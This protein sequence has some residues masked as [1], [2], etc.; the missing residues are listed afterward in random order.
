MKEFRIDKYWVFVFLNL[1]TLIAIGILA[2]WITLSWT[3]CVIVIMVDL[4]LLLILNFYT[5]YIGNDYN[6]LQD[7]SQVNI[8]VK[9]HNTR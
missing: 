4:Y 1:L 9:T 5:H 6:I 3:A 8:R 7:I 2:W